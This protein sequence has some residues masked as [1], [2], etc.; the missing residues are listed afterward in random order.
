VQV[1]SMTGYARHQGDAEGLGWIWEAKSVNGRGLDM[2]LRLPPGYDALEAPVRDL[3]SK[4]LRR[5]NINVSLTV[6]KT[7]ATASVRINEEV[8][9]RY[10]GLADRLAS[11]Y[12]FLAP[13]RIDG[14]LGLRGVI[15]GGDENSP[16][17]DS[18]PEAVAAERDRLQALLL[19]GLRTTL[20]SLCEMRAAEGARLAAL[21]LGQLADIENL[22]AQAVANPAI[23]PEALRDRLLNQLKPLLEQLPPLPEDRLAQEIA[24]LAGKADVREEVDRLTAHIAA[25][26]DLLASGEAIGRRLVSS[27]KN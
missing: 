17:E 25:A 9:A 12:P 20:E 15:D 22:T 3:I 11:D 8:L 27:V 18:P 2:R 14:L 10:V 6:T 13:A 16:I 19:A 23:S 26:R 4:T 7:A 1:S 21:V 5:G 24:L